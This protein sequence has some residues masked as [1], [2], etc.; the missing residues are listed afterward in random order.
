MNT[1]VCHKLKFSL[2]LAVLISCL[3]TF[4]S[5][6][7]LF[8]DIEPSNADA[9]TVTLNCTIHSI[10]SDTG[11]VPAEYAAL[12]MQSDETDS[13]AAIPTMPTGCT[14]TVSATADDGTTIAPQNLTENTF[15]IS[16]VSGKKWTVSVTMKYN[17]TTI[18][19]DSKEF[20]LTSVGAVSHDFI[21][22]PVTGGTGNISLTLA[23][24]ATSIKYILIT[25]PNQSA[26][27]W[28]K[29]T[30]YWA[31]PGSTSYVTNPTITLNNVNS[32]IYTATMRFYSGNDNNKALIYSTT[33]EINVLPT[34]TTNK[35]VS[36]GNVSDTLSITPTMVDTYGRT[37]FFVGDCGTATPDDTNGTG[38][39]Y[40][41]LATITK[42]VSLIST[43]PTGEYTIHVKDGTTE[44]ISSTITINK[45]I[46]IECWKNT[47]G[48]KLGTATL[49]RNADVEF[50]DITSGYFLTIDGVKT[51]SETWSGLVLDGAKDNGITG[52]CISNSGSLTLNGGTI[53]N[54]SG[55]FGGGVYSGGTLKIF[56]GVITD[57]SARIGG[58]I[59]SNGTLIM[60]DG[61]ITANQST[62]EDYGSGSTGGGGVYVN[63]GTFTMN[64]G[65]IRQ[66]TALYGG[67]GVYIHSSSTDAFIMN[68]G[69]IDSNSAPQG[70]GVYIWGSC[71]ATMNDGSISSNDATGTGNWKGGG[72]VY[73]NTGAQFTMTDGNINENTAA[74]CGGG[75]Y[76]YGSNGSFTMSGG[77][78]AGN[79]ATK[80]GGG[81]YL[82]EGKMYMHGTAVIGDP[83]ERN[84]AATSSLHSNIAT[85]GGGIRV[86]YSG[87]AYIGY[88]DANNV[89][90]FTGGIYYN[91][92]TSE[93]SETYHGG[94][95]IYNATK[96][97]NCKI[98]Y[99]GAKADGGGVFAGAGC[100][101]ENSEISFNA[102]EG[103]GGGICFYTSRNLLL[104]GGTVIGGNT[105]NGNG[106][107]IYHASTGSAVLGIEGTAYVQ[108][109]NDV[110]L[111]SG[112][113]ITVTG[114]LTPPSAA[115][116]IVATI[117]PD[118]YEA[119]YLANP[120]IVADEGVSTD[121]FTAASSKFAVTPNGDNSY[122]V[123]SD[124]SIEMNLIT[125]MNIT[126]STSLDS[127]TLTENK[128]YSFLLDNSVTADDITV[129]C[130]KLDTDGAN[131]GES[132]IDLSAS[133]FTDSLPKIQFGSA[134][135]TKIILPDSLT[136][137]G[138]DADI[139]GYNTKL[140]EIVYTGT[141]KIHLGNYGCE[142]CS[143][144]KIFPWNAIADGRLGNC[145]FIRCSSLESATIHEGITSIGSSAFKNCT[146][147]KEVHFLSS[148]PP[149]MS[150]GYQFDGCPDDLVFYVPTG[151]G[152]V[153]RAT[154]WVGSHSVIEE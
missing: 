66:N 8:D 105:A 111:T 60:D 79:E 17:G 39:P 20:D 5:C 70:G 122:R 119:T 34:L 67:G 109:S 71:T 123:K 47:V 90:S 76:V 59:Y 137:T 124:G 114:A 55:S 40:K 129:L 107:G 115:N 100:T 57:C 27:V 91:Y 1:K 127:L 10:F 46:T 143:S 140:V 50:F 83:S 126:S 104:S 48:D 75:V 11:A 2:F 32:G 117:S 92:A 131:I 102:T 93:S 133:S 7:N 134:N 44:D 95:G 30:N 53:K 152:D 125:N 4:I 110:Y 99:N 135:V 43:M 118:N 138:T 62:S 28:T 45:N 101:I 58:G 151:S 154:S 132:T 64:N 16:L 25:I 38:S 36:G 146:S 9:S 128:S 116:G 29:N 78:I 42:A 21:L 49:T 26:I 35:W 23:I 94:G 19:S 41:P 96:I 33:Q 72:G 87:A 18:L 74:E 112:K 120:V 24:G 113:K 52:S 88:S 86:D 37:D 153:Y 15:T 85:V 65:A 31:P 149:D 14:T 150:E 81:V 77:V 144:L 106:S 145:Y 56:G 142:N 139:F 80:D 63:N 73:V 84:S 69:E 103:N 51:G 54:C 3:A 130:Q 68:D 147:L 22:K 6:S 141:G 148:T 89:A 108:T 136:S 121:V 82:K 12:F 97:A 61:L 98:K 13:R